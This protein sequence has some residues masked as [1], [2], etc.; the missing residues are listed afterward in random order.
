MMST[1]PATLAALRLY[2]PGASTAKATR[3]WHRLSAPALAHHRKRSANDTLA[4]SM[5]AC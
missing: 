1:K 3:F 5:T 4:P 2:F